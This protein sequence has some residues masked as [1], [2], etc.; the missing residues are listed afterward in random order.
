MSR[1]TRSQANTS[2]ATQKTYLKHFSSVTTRKADK[3]DHEVQ[4]SDDDTSKKAGE[5]IRNLSI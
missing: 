5:L 1:T 2:N 4:A 3:N